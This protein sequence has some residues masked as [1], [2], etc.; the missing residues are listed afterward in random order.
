MS[1]MSQTAD[2]LLVIGRG[3]IIAAGPVQQV[4]D[5]VAGGA[6]RVR[7]PR[8]GELAAALAADG[9][10]R[11]LARGRDARCQWDH[12]GLAGLADPVQPHRLGRGRLHTRIGIKRRQLRRH[13]RDP[14]TGRTPR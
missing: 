3:R 9:A 10:T 12:R 11:H 8:A 1:E 4:I 7:S 14:S 13:P 2:H 6:V 5:S